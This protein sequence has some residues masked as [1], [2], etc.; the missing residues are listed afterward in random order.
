MHVGV[1]CEPRHKTAWITLE[2]R[3]RSGILGDVATTIARQGGNID[4]RPFYAETG[5]VMP[6]VLAVHPQHM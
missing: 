1:D 2:C 3:D 5:S 6:H 4:V